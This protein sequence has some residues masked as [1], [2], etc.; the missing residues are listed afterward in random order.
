MVSQAAMQTKCRRL[1]GAATDKRTKKIRNLK[2]E[3]SSITRVDRTK[4]EKIK[5]ITKST[6]EG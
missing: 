1:V 3:C 6:H 4:I 2:K 5:T